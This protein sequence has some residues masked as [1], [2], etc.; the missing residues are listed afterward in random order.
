[1][2]HWICPECGR[3]IP[4]TIRECPA[5]DPQASILAAP[6]IA[7][8]APLERS[9]PGKFA[10]QIAVADPVIELPEPPPTFEP[11]PPLESE[12][13]VLVS[14]ATAA[15]E[16]V[17]LANAAPAALVETA[18][19][20]PVEAIAAAIA[21]PVT[22][23]NEPPPTPEPVP[24]ASEPEISDPEASDLAS[25]S[26]VAVDPVSPE[27]SVVEVSAQ[28]PL[29][30]AADSREPEQ[31]IVPPPASILELPDPLLRLAQKLREAQK[32]LESAHALATAPEPV[33]EPVSL[34]E[35]VLPAEPEPQPVPEPQ[36]AQL[37]TVPLLAPRSLLLL[38]S[39]SAPVAL[40]APIQPPNTL[41]P[42][43]PEAK[44]DIQPAE[45]DPEAAGRVP[46][47]ELSLEP[48][49]PA[50]QP[51][52]LE[53]IAPASPSAPVSLSQ[54]S[55]SEP[56]L[57][58]APLRDPAALANRIRPASADVK[59]LRP[60][61]GPRITL[62]GPALPP[63]LHSLAN[64]GLSRILVDRPR[65]SK[66][67]RSSFRGLLVSVFVAG[68]LGAGLLGLALYNTPR[69]AASVAPSTSS[70][71]DPASAPASGSDAAESSTALPIAAATASY[72][73]SKAVE[74]TGLRF[75]GDK[76]S[77]VHYLLV[78]HAPAE[79]KA[80][81]VYVT[82]R[83]TGAKP[84]QPP[85][86]RFSFRAPALAAF[87]SREMV[88]TL[89]KPLHAAADWQSMRADVELGQ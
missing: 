73:L 40:L 86:A 59:I 79:L 56:A 84:G 48:S 7:A 70:S 75:P 14:R 41:P 36:R 2:F 88:A 72:S 44:P 22:E 69:T 58:L 16:T 34:P 66:G 81:T 71:N 21:D 29:A 20:K 25:P 61:T 87:E 10:E 13:P 65:V 17:T 76:G 33:P 32:E 78:N 77:E 51:A 55:P 28:E 53:S 46:V 19:V 12:A 80:V 26:T 47:P 60:E 68:V 39:G 6:P 24:L 43:L 62:P 63:A 31:T 89:D 15:A 5:C 57:I 82:L 35:P 11:V 54:R 37:N 8:A 4:P 45:P 1:M 67:S 27:T 38:D 18:P 52:T 42:A 49:A 23:L 9:A 50:P 64:A 74:V 3:E 83:A 85:L 30:P